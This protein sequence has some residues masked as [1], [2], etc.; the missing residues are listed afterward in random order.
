MGSCCQS[1]FLVVAGAKTAKGASFFELAPPQALH[2]WGGDASRFRGQIRLTS[3]RVG[4]GAVS[5]AGSLQPRIIAD[6]LAEIDLGKRVV[7]DLSCRDLGAI[8]SR[9]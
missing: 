6:G 4:V 7:V 5:G 9:H 8:A 3:R 2:R 1:A